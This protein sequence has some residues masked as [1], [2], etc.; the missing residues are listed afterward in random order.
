M[1]K[2][3]LS[4]N[5]LEWLQVVEDSPE[6]WEPDMLDHCLERDGVCKEDKDF[7]LRSHKALL[8]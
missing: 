1:D 3:E 7:I 4:E 5:A 6:D 2:S 8:H